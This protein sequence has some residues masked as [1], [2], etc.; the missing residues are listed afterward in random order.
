MP[1]YEEEVSQVQ[2]FGHEL[3]GSKVVTITV[4]TP[5]YTNH[6]CTV[7]TQ[8]IAPIYGTVA[9]AENYFR[10]KISN[11]VKDWTDSDDNDRMAALRQA[12]RI[13]ETLN[14]RGL[15]AVSTQL[16]HF[17]TDVHGMPDDVQIACY[18]IALKL[19]SGIDPDTEQDNLSVTSQGYAAG[20]STFDRSFVQDHVRA[21]VPSA[22]AW[23]ILRP[24]LCDPKAIRTSRGS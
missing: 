5:F 1:V 9:G 19:L 16:L 12:T 13:I 7:Y 21:G 24:Y 11:T 17:P 18:E 8:A 22:F 4:V 3:V 15:P 23:S 2:T 6:V 10:G 20:R 14:F